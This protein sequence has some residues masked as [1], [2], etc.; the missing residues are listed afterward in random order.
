MR[1]VPVGIVIR[2]FPVVSVPAGVPRS[3]QMAAVTQA[4]VDQLAEGIAA[5]PEDWHMLQKVFV[6]DL[7]PARDA[8]TRAKDSESTG[9]GW[10]ARY[11]PEGRDRVPVLVR[12][13]RW[14]AVPHP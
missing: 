5:D 11:E 14:R 4:W 12:R 3:E 2:F 7:D 9:G 8:R 10:W 6:A 13:P 1:R